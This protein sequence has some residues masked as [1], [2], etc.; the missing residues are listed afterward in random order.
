[1]KMAEVIRLCK[2]ACPANVAW[3]PDEP[4]GEFNIGDLNKQ[5][6]KVLYCVTPTREVIAY[7]RSHN[8]DLLISHHP[9]RVDVPQL[10]FHTALDCCEGGL[11]DQWRDHVGLLPP[12]DHFDGTLG[13]YGE[14]KPV[15]FSELCE[16]VRKLSRSIDGEMFA[17]SPEF[18]VKSVVICSGLGGYVTD[19]ALATNADCYILGENTRPAA[20]TGFR[21]VIETGHTNSEWMGVLLFKK[22][23]H[24]V[25]VDLAPREIDYF[26]RERACA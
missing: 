15:S 16:R 21:C 3:T 13:W 7:V 9:F 22:I 26:G 8:Y 19:L 10:I 14:I 11:N 12:Y 2:A 6:K 1:M 18:Q 23:L 24:G 25:Q 4:Y 5:V 20:L 17:P